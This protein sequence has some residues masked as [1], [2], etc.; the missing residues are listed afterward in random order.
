MREQGDTLAKLIADPNAYFYVCGLKAMEDGVLA[1][2]RDICKAH[3]IDWAST[4]AD[5]KRSGRLHL[6]TY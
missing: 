5:M 3:N 4:A 6:E 1:A 2:M